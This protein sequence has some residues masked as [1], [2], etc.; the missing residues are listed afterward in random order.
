MAEII[1]VPFSGAGGG[2]PPSGPASGDLGGTYPGPT[3]VGIQTVPVSAA[4]PAVGDVLSLVAGVWTPVPMAGGGTLQSSYTGGGT[5]AVTAGKPIAFSNAVDITDL[6]TLTRTFG[7]A[8]DALS[9]SM[10]AGATGRGI[11]ID[12]GGGSGVVVS[13]GATDELT[14]DP[15]A[16]TQSAGD[17]LAISVAGVVG[18]SISVIAGA[19]G[20][21]AGGDL[22]LEAGTGT[23]SGVINIGEVG[24][25]AVNIGG[26]LASTQNMTL[27]ARASSILLN[28]PTAADD[29]LVGFTATSIIGALN[30]L[31]AAPGNNLQE[32]YDT[33]PSPFIVQN[34][35]GGMVISRGTAPNGDS[36]LALSHVVAAPADDVLSIIHTPTSAASGGNAISITVNNN[37]A[38]V[39]D[40]IRII[41]SDTS[42]ITNIAEDGIF[43]A[44][45]A[46]WTLRPIDAPAA[47]AGVGIEIISGLGGTTGAG[48][49]LDLAAGAGGPSNGDGGSVTI[50]GGDGNV[51]NADGGDVTIE[52]GALAGTGTD[53]VINIGETN[54]SAINIGGGLSATQNM[55]LSARASSILLN[56]PTA[57]D[58]SLDASF[59]AT[60]IVGALNEIQTGSFPMTSLP[61]EYTVPGAVGVQ[62]IVYITGSSTADVTDRTSAA[63][64][65]AIGV[66]IAK[67][68]ATTATL[69]YVGPVSG[70]ATLTPGAE[71]YIGT[72]GGIE[73]PSA[74]GDGDVV[75]R[76]GVAI[77]ADILLFNPDPTTTDL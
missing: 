76:A 63:T 12:V 67:P 57:A 25:S 75:Q 35:S 15:G 62:D 29:T 61:G 34:A 33:A 66:V 47:T 53:G 52:A 17:D 46:T 7:G 4:V 45:Q 40:A 24:A 50:S 74:A 5:I 42:E 30:E 64:M 58:D 13:D 26:A 20:G 9:V 14:V 68:T 49:D 28:G 54:A 11:F 55:T 51:V 41:N 32:A 38:A 72:A 44:A 65:P 36:L 37:I 8:G 6:L 22:D 10:A 73:S 59:T 23:P 56:G 3:V 60:S 31:Q 21:G 77:T 1:F 18:G 48:G 70:F 2:G 43:P 71:Y 39:N 27:S 19:G 16:I 69:A